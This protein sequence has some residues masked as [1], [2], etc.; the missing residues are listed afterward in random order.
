M[1]LEPKITSMLKKAFEMERQTKI[2][3]ILKKDL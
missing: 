1:S 3:S 2:A